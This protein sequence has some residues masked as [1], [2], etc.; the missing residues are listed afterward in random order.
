[1]KRLFCLLCLCLTGTLFAS[2]QERKA[3][4][5][6][7]IIGGISRSIIDMAFAEGRTTDEKL[8]IHWAYAE[9]MKDISREHLGPFSDQELR[10]ILSYYRSE[11]Y[12]YTASSTFLSIY[13]NNILNAIQ[14]ELGGAADFS[15]RLNDTGYGNGLDALLQT[16]MAAKQ[17]VIDNL[18][19][20]NGTLMTTARNSGASEAEIKQISKAVRNIVDHLPDL[21]RLSLVDYLSNDAV[22]EM[23]AFLNSSTGQKF[24][25]YSLKT[26]NAMDLMAEDC[27]EK[28]L[29]E[30]SD[31]EKS[32]ELKKSLA[33]F[34]SIS[35]AFPEYFPELYRPYRELAIGKNTYMGQTRDL[36]PHGK[37]KLVDRKGVVYE[38]FFKGG[39]RHG[40]I[41]VA[42]PGKEAVVEFWHDDRRAKGILAEAGEDGRDFPAQ[43]ISGKRN[44]YGKVYDNGILYKGLFVDGNLNGYGEVL[45]QSRHAKG[46]F[47]DGRLVNGTISISSEELKLNRFQGMFADRLRKGLHDLISQDGTRKERQMGLFVDGILDGQGQRTVSDTEQSLEESGIFANGKLYGKG[48]RRSGTV[49]KD[50]GICAREK[51]TGDFS[52]GFFHGSGILSVTFTDI[53]EGSWTF[54]YCGVKLHE[55]KGDSLVVTMEGDFDSGSFEKGRLSRSDGSWFEGTF[56]RTGLIDGR[57]HRKYSNGSY[58]IGEC[59]DGKIHGEGEIHYADGTS[60]VGKFESGYP[61]GAG[62]RH[63]DALPAEDSGQA[64]SVGERLETR[65]YRFDD[66]PVEKGKVRLVTAAGVKIM[67]RKVSSLDVTCEG[68]F[69]RKTGT[70]LDGKVT[71]SDGNWME[72]TFEDGVL[73]RGKGRSLDKYGTIYEGEIKNGFPHGKG[74]CIYSDGTWFKGTFA[75]GNRMGGTH[76]TADGKV[77]KVYK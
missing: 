24:A 71:M 72:G 30:W 46:E 21:F 47:I 70:L 49:Y 60:Y 73:I 54:T 65:T 26:G 6:S 32:Y 17:P 43:V 66:L 19:G 4:E 15:Y 28:Y 69:D 13:L 5:D 20:E 7:V 63:L 12:R 18:I 27:F 57:M 25:E 48:T 40:Q 56:G 34:V 64:K 23:M 16:A 77:I 55:F 10:N 67:V 8:V 33:E 44:G 58:Y 1:M 75:N 14:Y 53:P 76:Y 74:K 45:E 31:P 50:Y 11:A 68:H 42:K 22:E 37:G 39:K 9:F 3:L 51:Y 29:E 52:S 35:R 41:T 59:K 38:G 36:L 61:V 2:A 62:S